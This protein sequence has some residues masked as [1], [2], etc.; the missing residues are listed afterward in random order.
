MA[1]RS[2]GVGSR[3]SRNR[4]SS[5]PFWSR[6]RVAH[7]GPCPSRR[8]TRR[9]G[10]T[11]GAGRT[12][13]GARQGQSSRPGEAYEPQAL[14]NGHRRPSEHDGHSDPCALVKG[15]RS[16]RALRAH[17]ARLRW[18]T[19][20]QGPASCE[21]VRPEGRRRRWRTSVPPPSHRGHARTS[22]PRALAALTPGHTGAAAG[23]RTLPSVA[24]EK[25]T[26]PKALARVMKVEVGVGPGGGSAGRA[27][28]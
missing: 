20:G 13:S 25:T 28:R 26:L 5:G 15:E 12:A 17:G 21:T 22:S 4:G 6:S 16:S 8:G 3:T 19:H 14:D 11:Q 24:G 1:R 2:F 23:G 9:W 10:T 18:H 7:G 27:L